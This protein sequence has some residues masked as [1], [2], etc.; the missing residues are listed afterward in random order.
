MTH[1]SPAPFLRLLPAA[2]A[3]GLL[4]LAA[5]A[6]T[7][8]GAAELLVRFDGGIGSQPLR[9]GGLVNDVNGTPPGGRP[10]VISELRA[11]VATDGRINVDGRGLVL[12]G[13]SGIATGGGQSVRARLYCAGVPHDSIDLV[14]LETNGDFR[15]GG[16]LAAT[17]PSPCNTPVLLIINGNGSWFAAGVP[18]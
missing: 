18:K 8:A 17:P 1:A 5:L 11:Q 2:V 13:G 9:A 14:P 15:I 7:A 4:A 12:A 3:A 10:W 16:F 6:P